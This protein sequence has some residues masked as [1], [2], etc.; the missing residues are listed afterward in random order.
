MSSHWNIATRE[1]GGGGGKWVSGTHQGVE[2]RTKAQG[3]NK[4][5]LNV[6]E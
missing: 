4:E 1:R 3:E 2:A 5:D 6:E